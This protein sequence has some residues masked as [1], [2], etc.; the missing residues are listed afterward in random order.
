MVLEGVAGVGS[1][2]PISKGGS[3]TGAEGG[4]ASD[5]DGGLV[6]DVK[7]GELGVSSAEGALGWE[8]GQGA[9]CAGLHSEKPNGNKAPALPVA[10]QQ[11]V[12]VV[13]SCGW[14]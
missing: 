5:E 12:P 14:L 4:G 9:G 11:A 3:A 7:G 8:A 6:T 2:G 1:S 10:A 13:L